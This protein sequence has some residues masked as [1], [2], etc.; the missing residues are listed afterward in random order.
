MFSYIEFSRAL[1]WSEALVTRMV[2]VKVIGVPL[3][4]QSMRIQGRLELQS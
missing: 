4:L 2:L 3:R 1:G